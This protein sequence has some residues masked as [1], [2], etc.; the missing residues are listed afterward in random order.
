MYELDILKITQ[1]TIQFMVYS[2]GFAIF[3]ILGVKLSLWICEIIENFVIGLKGM[4]IEWYE[5]KD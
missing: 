2:F 3:I 5:D 1:V 4:I